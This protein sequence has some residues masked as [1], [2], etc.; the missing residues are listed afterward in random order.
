MDRVNT[1]LDSELEE[2]T[3][4]AGD[5]IANPRD[6]FKRQLWVSQHDR[7]DELIPRVL[8]S[9][10]HWQPQNSGFS[11]TYKGQIYR[12][13]RTSI[14]SAFD[15]DHHVLLVTRRTGNDKSVFMTHV[16]DPMTWKT[17]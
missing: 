5:A 14:T 16:V 12:R 1:S 13:E 10:S 8:A 15:D 7:Y 3:D 2:W 6:Y 4:E 9:I 17:T 11:F